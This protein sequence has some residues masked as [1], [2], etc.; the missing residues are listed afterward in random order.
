MSRRILLA[1]LAWL[2]PLAALAA[3]A[4]LELPLLFSDGAV[5]Q[6]DRPLPVWGRAAPGSQVEVEFDGARAAATAG[7]DG[8]WSLRLP[9]HAAGGPYELVVRAG[10]RERRVRDVLVGEVWLA[11]G[12]SNMEWPV[13]ETLHAAEDIA[14]AGDRRLRHF[15]IPKSWAERPQADLAGGQWQAASPDTV[16]AFSAVA[17]AFARELRAATGVPV[18]II[19]STW[20]GSSIEAWMDAAMLGLDADALEARM[21]QARAAD[22][23]VRAR[24]RERLAAWPPVDAA[25]EAFAAAPLDERDWATIQ[26]PALWEAA[27]YPGVDGVAWYRTAFELDAREAA[28]GVTLGLGRIDDSDTVWVNGRRVGATRNGWNT[29]RAYA[30]PPSA[31][32]AGRNTVAVRVEDS[33]GGGGIAGRADELYLATAG[34]ARRALAG[35]WRF[36]TA[37]VDVAM[38]EGKNQVDTALY[39]AMVHPL[40][41]YPLAGVIWYQGETNATPQGAHAYRD[42]FGALIRGW[43][44]AWQ[45][46][47]L[48]FLW[49]QLAAFGSGGDRVDAAGTVIDSPWATLRESQSAVLALPAT[50]QAVTID[51]G[52]AHDI[53]P[54]DKRT[55]GHRLA[56][57]ARRVA[58]GQD[59]VHAGP[60]YRGAEARE[61][62]LVLRFDAPAGLAV[63]GGGQAPRGFELAGADGR[64]H[65]AQAR[66]EGDAV[67]LRSGAVPQPRLARYAWSDNPAAADLVGGDGLPASPFR[68]G[69]W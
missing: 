17:Y 58:Y 44:A 64:F 30:V 56:L 16:G 11:S 18:G 42:R 4:A 10:G 45:A 48:P 3:D 67:V 69:E 55:V 57:A 62:T 21:R 47:E 12:Q 60:A 51:V 68:T 13:Q 63:R 2:L 9:A 39:N 29:P 36:R 41:P 5:L 50:A 32:R 23:A 24:T 54:R 35:P 27:G 46:P 15:K 25:S 38:D 7:A 43:R 31:L 53:H 28:A 22:E 40:Q 66:I 14:A 59:V 37:A 65:P 61:G 19:D 49:A 1:L 6:R 26:V 20:G 8:R 52:D 33:G 34:G